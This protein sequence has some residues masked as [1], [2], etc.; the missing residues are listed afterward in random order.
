[1]HSTHQ[2]RWEKTSDAPNSKQALQHWGALVGGGAL[3]I[4]GLTRRSS[5][6][7]A[8]AAAGGALAYKGLR[9]TTSN[10]TQ[11][12]PRDDRP[13][14]GSNILVNASPQDT[15]R[16]W[17][18]LENAPR[19]MN[20]IESV[21]M[22]DE[23]RSRWTAVG[24]MGAKLSWTAE[25]TDERPGEYIAWRS[26]P[27]SDLNVEGRVEFKQAPGK[28]GT[29]VHST[30]HYTL[31]NRALRGAASGFVGQQAKF[32]MRQDLRRFKA[33]IETGEIP[34]TRGQSHGPRSRAAAAVRALNPDRPL[35]GQWRATEVVESMRRVS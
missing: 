9:A 21:N 35:R 10:G 34:T 16:L 4:F 7:W 30:M 1:M 8:L 17:R 6:G 23:R 15:F 25:I 14:L 26:L 27:G 5:A 12:S 18:D 11:Q 29:V 13:E 20:H 19:F 22:L 28:R 3:A 31:A 24:P 33:L 32:F 2:G